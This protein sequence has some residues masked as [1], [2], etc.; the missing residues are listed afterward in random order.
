MLRRL[1][2]ALALGLAACT[3]I[4]QPE[5]AVEFA[6][7]YAHEVD[8]RLSLPPAE[9]QSYAARLFDAL[10]T[11][12]YREPQFAV[13][14]DRSP[15]VQAVFVYWGSP[16][17]GMVARRR[18]AGLDRPA[19]RVRAL[20]DAAGRI[21]ALAGE[22]GFSRR[23]HAQQERHPRLRHGRDARLR[24]RLGAAPRTWGARG[25]GVMRLQMHATDKELLEPLLGVRHSKGCI[26]IPHR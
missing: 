5:P 15:M 3:A 20:R 21:R 12:G 16:D 26:R 11:A 13:M 4:A 6:G 2:A 25:P 14:V 17:Q 18:L 24:F 9:A 8:R 10:A 7:R 19:R 23:R 1:F 22:S